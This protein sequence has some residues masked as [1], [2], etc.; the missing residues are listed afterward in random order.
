[1]RRSEL[2][3]AQALCARYLDPARPVLAAVSG[4][5][6]S[7]CLLYFL[8]EQGYDVA[9]AHFNHRL[10]G[11]EA[12][13]DEQFVRAW[14]E[15]RAIPFYAGSGDVR[16]YARENGRSVEEAARTLRHAFLRQTA[17]ALHAQLAL[18]HHADDNAETVLLN[19]IRGTD[20][21]GL[22]GMKPLQGGIVR[23]LLTQTRAELAAYASARGVPHVE[24]R[25]NADPDAAAR[26]YLRLDIL[27]RLQTLN[28][29]ASEHIAAAARSLTA[30]DDALERETDALMAR[31]SLEDG[32]V[33]L[34]LEAFR[35]APEAV[36]ARAV[37]RMADL[38]G[39]GR[40]DIVRAQLEA[41]FALA[42][43]SGR[44]E[45]SV[46]LPRGARALCADGALTVELSHAAPREM[47][48]LPN[49]P[50]RWGGY[51]L[52]LLSAPDGEGLSLRAL[53]PDET[54][55]VLP[56]D[57]GSFL[58]LAGANGA[59]SV[60]RLCL[61]RRI[62]PSVRDTLPAFYVNGRLAAV[63]PLGAD[64]SFSP[65]Q[66]GERCFI[67][68]FPAQDFCTLHGDASPC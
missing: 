25:T 49:V 15:A 54:L 31:A 27:P 60:K 1:M 52:T 38:L 23:P 18:A 57:A 62:P 43:K 48:L 14:C 40:R 50:A 65:A 10:R 35:A 55:R 28:P 21:R 42:Q 7:M 11:A 66:G 39:L 16:A 22:C 6:D 46:S 17:D 44:A 47:P 41:I 12:D 29:R 9:C 8:R 24:D 51:A 26:N 2:T 63:W 59:R 13:G 20:L 19:L 5:L 4:G 58:T 32:R 37:L 45:C 36:R 61:D 33:T 64:I 3:G 34:P 56:C 53:L 30:L 67:R 68:V